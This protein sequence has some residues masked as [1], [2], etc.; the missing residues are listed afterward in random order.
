MRIL[1]HCAEARSV[2][3]CEYGA[4]GASLRSWRTGADAGKPSKEAGGAN[5]QQFVR[6][7]I[8][9]H[10]KYLLVRG[11]LGTGISCSAGTAWNLL[12]LVHA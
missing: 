8:E 10:D 5:E 12:K 4:C 7:V 1:A 3:M 2:Q 6:D 11:V 9:L